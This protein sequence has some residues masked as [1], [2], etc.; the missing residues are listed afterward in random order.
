MNVVKVPS[1]KDVD[2]AIEDNQTLLAL[3]DFEGKN[4]VMCH[5][6]DVDNDDELYEKSG[7]DAANKAKFFRVIF[8]KQGA[9]WTFKLPTSYKDIGNDRDR[10]VAFYKDGFAVLSEFLQ[11]QGYFVG[12]DIPTR[13]CKFKKPD[14]PPPPKTFF[15]T[16][17]WF[18]YVLIIFAILF[19]IYSFN[20]V[21]SFF[22]DDDKKSGAVFPANQIV[23]EV[24]AE[25]DSSR[26]DQDLNI[27]L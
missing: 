13:Y 2:K 4:A 6:D 9:D 5:I 12:I 14:P 22:K 11:L 17:P 27:L 15:Q 19:V 24:L 8:N 1:E 3:V 25:E 23:G 18:V 10:M 26:F 7:F 21:M 16:Y 20:F